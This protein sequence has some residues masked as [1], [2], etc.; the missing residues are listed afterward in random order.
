MKTAIIHSVIADNDVLADN[1]WLGIDMYA[2]VDA[3]NGDVVGGDIS[4][5]ALSDR[6][7]A[8]G[9]TVVDEDDVYIHDGEKWVR[10]S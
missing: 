10:K 6:L 5:R 9:W 1:D 3:D 4:W 2:A 8:E 7:R